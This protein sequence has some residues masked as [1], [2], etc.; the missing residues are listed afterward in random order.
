MNPQGGASENDVAG[1]SDNAARLARALVGWAVQHGEAS[2]LDPAA[3]AGVYLAAAA[4]RLSRL[5][6]RRPEVY[7]LGLTEEAAGPA[8][9]RLVTLGV[10]GAQLR[11]DDVMELTAGALPKVEVV[12]GSPPFV[13]YQRVSRERRALAGNRAAAA[14]VKLDALAGSWASL[15]IHSGSFLKVGGRLAMLLPSEVGHARYARD[16]IAYLRKRF[17]NVRFVLFDSPLFPQFDQ[18]VVLLLASGYGRPNDSFEVATVA[19]PVDLP[20]LSRNGLDSLAYR[21]IEA[22]ALVSGRSR[23][24]HAWLEPSTRELVTWLKSSRQVSRLGAHA[25]VT[26]GYISAAND[27]FHLAPYE[28]VELDLAA[29]HLRRALFRSRGLVSLAFTDGDWLAAAERGAAGLLFAPVDDVEPAVAAYLRHGQELGLPN[30]A[31]ARQRSPWWRVTRTAAPD[32]LLTAMT[33]DSPLLSVNAVQVAVSNT[34]HAVWRRAGSG[35]ATSATLAAA[36]QSSLTALSAEMEGRP[37][38]GGLLKLEPSAAQALLL[39]V[40]AEHRAE[41][42]PAVWR[43]IDRRLRAGDELGAA[44]AADVAFLSGIP[45]VG[46]DGSEALAQAAATLRRVR[47]G[48]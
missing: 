43:T 44:E 5:G 39:P 18:A 14:G 28:A 34:L 26:S 22:E 40:P 21:G 24:H 41:V 12:V 46:E 2:V 20:K 6:A 16:V 27:Y 4:E 37:L 13:R 9:Q 7:G 10:D 47:R 29:V 30:R 8:R 31:K 36:A 35:A 32:L 42:E 19:G 23:L 48:P 38:G 1:A 15:V 17:A 3:G 33:N 25:R 45:G 11:T